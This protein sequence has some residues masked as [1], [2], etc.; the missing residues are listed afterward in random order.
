VIRRSEVTA[1]YV[2]DDQGRVLLRQL[3]LGSVAGEQGMEVLAG[4]APGEKVALD[5]VRAGIEAA[6]QRTK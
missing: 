4:L 3:R 6:R 5:P 1:A 2:V